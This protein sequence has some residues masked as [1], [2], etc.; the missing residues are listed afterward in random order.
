MG[1]RQ[2]KSTSRGKKFG[3]SVPTKIATVAPVK[4]VRTNSAI[5]AHKQIGPSVNHVTFKKSSVVSHRSIGSAMVVY[6]R[7]M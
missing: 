2:I 3:N 6:R 1:I 7:I 5:V 4:G